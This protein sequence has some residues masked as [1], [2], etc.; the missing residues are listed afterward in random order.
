MPLTHF[1]SV[2]GRVM[3][4]LSQCKVL[5]KDG[6]KVLEPTTKSEYYEKKVNIGNVKV[7]GKID[8]SKFERKK[9]EKKTRRISISLI[10]M[11]L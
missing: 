1:S 5:S 3:A 11:Y 6:E 4:Y 10:Q 7:V 8:L 2:S 9:K